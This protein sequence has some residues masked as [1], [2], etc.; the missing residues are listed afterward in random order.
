MRAAKGSDPPSM[1]GFEGRSVPTLG[2]APEQ[3]APHPRSVPAQAMRVLRQGPFGP[4]AAP[5][6]GA[7]RDCGSVLDDVD[8]LLTSINERGVEGARGCAGGD[9]SKEVAEEIA[10]LVA[11]PQGYGFDSGVVPYL[12]RY[13]TTERLLEQLEETL[14]LMEARGINLTTAWEL[15]RTAR[16]LLESADIVQALICANRALR[17]ALEVNRLHMAPG[18]AAS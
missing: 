14:H 10:E 5:P 16:A 7:D 3:G 1:E 4:E 2:A 15:V 12:D 9:S 18:G 11:E 8:D 6:E 13:E 17:V